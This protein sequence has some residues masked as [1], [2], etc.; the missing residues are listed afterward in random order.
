MSDN[1]PDKLLSKE[2]SQIIE[3]MRDGLLLLDED[4]NVMFA[5]KTFYKLFEVSP[6]KSIGEKIYNLGDGQWD[7][8]ELKTFIEETLTKVQ[9]FH[10][11]KVTHEFPTIG[12]KTMLL[13]GR[14]IKEDGVLTLLIISDVTNIEK[15]TTTL[16]TSL[17]IADKLNVIM[18]DREI[19]MSELKAEV[20]TLK[21]SLSEAL[22]EDSVK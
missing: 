15:A 10:D 1:A 11:F 19:R 17:A 6:E 8:A 20:L 16:K 22:Q 7:I 14:K 21:K 4:L 12:E 2:A 9:E 3:T 13:N 5:N 18:A